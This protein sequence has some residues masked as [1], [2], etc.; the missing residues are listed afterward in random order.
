MVLS[1]GSTKASDDLSFHYHRSLIPYENER[2][3]FSK[4]AIKQFAW[5]GFFRI[6]RSVVERVLV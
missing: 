6:G 4:T 3:S 5:N 1:T 2:S